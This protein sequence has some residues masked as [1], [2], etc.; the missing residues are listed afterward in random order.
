[1][2]AVV[3]FAACLLL[4]CAATAQAEPTAGFKGYAPIAPKPAG[5]TALTASG[6]RDSLEWGPSN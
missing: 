1:M 3:L 4:A 6:N 5:L 2:L